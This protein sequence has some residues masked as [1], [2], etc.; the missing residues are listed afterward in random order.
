MHLDGVLGSW[1]WLTS[2]VDLLVM[3]KKNATDVAGMQSTQ[4]FL[5]QN[6]VLNLIDMSFNLRY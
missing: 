5:L 6:S 3:V 1:P 4:N 2:E